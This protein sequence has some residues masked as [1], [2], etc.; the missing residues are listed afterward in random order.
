MSVAPDILLEPVQ[1]GGVTIPVRTYYRPRCLRCGWQDEP[2]PQRD[3][4]LVTAG[5]HLRFACLTT[6]TLEAESDPLPDHP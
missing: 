2:Y 3:Q 4:A 5:H 6:S 1:I